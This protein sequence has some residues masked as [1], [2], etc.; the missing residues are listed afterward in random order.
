MSHLVV[1]KSRNCLA[2]TVAMV[3]SLILLINISFKI[4]ALHGIIFSASSVLCAIIASLYLFVLT[5]CSIDEQRHILNQSLLSL[6]LFSIGI[7]L[8]VNL[9]ADEYMRD[10]TA[11][12]IVFEDIPRKFFAATLA[13]GLSFYLPHLFCCAKYKTILTQ[14]NYRF[15]LAFSG[16]CAFFVLDFLLLFA[17]LKIDNILRIYIDSSMVNLIIILL[18]GI[19]YFFAM[20]WPGKSREEG[21]NSVCVASTSYHYLIS[22]AVTILLICLA[23]EYRLVN[24]ANGWTLVASGILFPLVLMASNLIGE[25]YGYKANLRFAV[26]LV[27][28]ELAFDV[29]LMLVIVLPAPDFFDLNPFYAFIMPR[30]IPATALGLLVSLMTNALLLHYLNKNNYYKQRWLRIFFANIIVN[31]LLCMVNYSLLFAGIYPYEEIFNLVVNAWVYKFLVTLLLLP[32]MLWT[33]DIL[34]KQK[35]ARILS[36]KSAKRDY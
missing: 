4:I 26:I 24:F 18:A 15:I 9:P 27:V 30:R 1:K 17:D 31:S 21:V 22:F 29:V 8:L 7:F 2:L 3:C 28:A 33:Y 23:C 14:V 20:I 5:D 19:V 36:N 35:T 10:N 6:Y 12:Q 13:Y 25:L 16:G 34:S 11:Y 32:P